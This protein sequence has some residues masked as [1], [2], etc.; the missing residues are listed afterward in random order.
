[1]TV[2]HHQPRKTS[3]KTGAWGQLLAWET[4]AAVIWDEVHKRRMLTKGLVPSC[5]AQNLKPG[6]ASPCSWQ[7]GGLRSVKRP[8]RDGSPER[9]PLHVTQ[10]T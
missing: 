2:N 10:G 6:P 7:G 4:E 5:S 8:F 9:P 3:L 1:M